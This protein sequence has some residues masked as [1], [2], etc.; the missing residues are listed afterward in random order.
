[1]GT[2]HPGGFGRLTISRGRSAVASFKFI[3]RQP[4]N[5]GVSTLRKMPRVRILASG[6]VRHAR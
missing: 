4:S 5:P 1:M 2:F 6:E 3:V